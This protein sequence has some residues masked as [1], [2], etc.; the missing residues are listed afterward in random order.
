MFDGHFHWIPSPDLL[1]LE[2]VCGVPL[3][4]C[5]ELL[6]CPGM[7]LREGLDPLREVLL[8]SLMLGSAL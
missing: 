4:G 3:S 8:R 7:L 6:L 2:H 1:E 5:L